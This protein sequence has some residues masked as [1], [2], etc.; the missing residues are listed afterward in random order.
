[1]TCRHGKGDIKTGCFEL[2]REESG[3]CPLIGQAVSGM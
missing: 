3:G 1:M 2:A